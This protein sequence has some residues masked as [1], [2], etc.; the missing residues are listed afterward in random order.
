MSV[1]TTAKGRWK[2]GSRNPY[3]ESRFIAYLHFYAYTQNA[4]RS[5]SIDIRVESLRDAEGSGGGQEGTSP[6]ISRIM[7]HPGGG[8]EIRR[9]MS[10]GE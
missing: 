7:N 4:C 9:N 2:E 3:K 5:S 10:C 8:D 1:V 6:P